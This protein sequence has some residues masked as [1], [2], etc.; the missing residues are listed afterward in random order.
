MVMRRR[1]IPLAVLAA[2]AVA[3]PA[4]ADST[5][6]LEPP[7]RPPVTIRGWDVRRGD[8]LGR[9][10]LLVRRLTSATGGRSRIIRLRCPSGTRHAGLGTFDASRIAFGVVGGNYVGHRS[11]R[12]RVIAPPGTKR[13]ATVR[14][15]I[16]AL[17]ATP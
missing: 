8:R 17:C 13:G 15:S 1:L 9:G 11:V 16:F 7:A 5:T 2:L 3:A 14:A 12:V 10:Q 4:K 6:V